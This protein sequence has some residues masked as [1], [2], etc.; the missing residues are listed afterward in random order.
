MPEISDLSLMTDRVGKG[1]FSMPCHR[2]ELIGSGIIWKNLQPLAAFTH[3][4]QLSK[5]D[6]HLDPLLSSYSQVHR[7]FVWPAFSST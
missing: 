5:Q 7:A 1:W 2:S 6:R 3:D 4:T